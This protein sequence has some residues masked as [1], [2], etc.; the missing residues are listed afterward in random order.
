MNS[1]VTFQTLSCEHSLVHCIC[2]SYLQLQAYILFLHVEKRKKDQQTIT[3]RYFTG[4]F[5]KYTI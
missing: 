4:D 5:K 2:F 1:A 3:L